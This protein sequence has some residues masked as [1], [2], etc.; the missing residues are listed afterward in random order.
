MTSVKSLL[1]LAQ[2]DKDEFYMEAAV[3]LFNLLSLKTSEVEN[4]CHLALI[5][6]MEAISLRTNRS[7]NNLGI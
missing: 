5:I 2:V 3:L 6:I 4:L 7:F 1:E